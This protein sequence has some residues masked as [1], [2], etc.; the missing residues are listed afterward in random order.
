[1]SIG[2][3]LNNRFCKGWKRSFVFDS[4]QK[5][6]SLLERTC[7]LPKIYSKLKSDISR[8]ILSKSFPVYFESQQAEEFSRLSESGL[9]ISGC[10]LDSIESISSSLPPQLNESSRPLEWKASVSHYVYHGSGPEQA[11]EIPVVEGHRQISLILTSLWRTLIPA[12]ANRVPLDLLQQRLAQ[13]DHVRA[14]YAFTY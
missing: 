3:R 11:C 8:S 14:S 6:S 4:A 13:F 2:L 5:R 10:I 1:M 7:K 12:A 9:Q